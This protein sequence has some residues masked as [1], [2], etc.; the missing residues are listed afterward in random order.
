VGPAVGAGVQEGGVSM[1]SE[2]ECA[3]K[4]LQYIRTGTRLNSRVKIELAWKEGD[5]TQMAEGYTVDVSPKGCMAIAPQ[6]LAVGLKLRLK[7]K[8]NQKETEAQL[9]WKGHQGRTGWELGLELVD[10]PADFW[11]VEF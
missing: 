6:E 10:P 4:M 1:P 3:L 7:N 9:I 8:N 5:H 2:V 11:G